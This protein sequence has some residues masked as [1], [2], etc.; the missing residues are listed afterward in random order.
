MKKEVAYLSLGQPLFFFW[1]FH[2]EIFFG[3]GLVG[4]VCEKKEPAIDIAGLCLPLK[5]QKE[6][7]RNIFH[8]STILLLH[9]LSS[10]RY[11]TPLY[12]AVSICYIFR[13]IQKRISRKTIK[14]SG[15]LISVDSRDCTYRMEML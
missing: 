13:R 11:S 2:S 12:L 4:V 5:P 1:I 10:D 15:R 7:V 9:E 14:S 6:K 8:F 3:P